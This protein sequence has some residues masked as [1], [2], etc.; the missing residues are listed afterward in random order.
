MKNTKDYKEIENLAYSVGAGIIVINHDEIANIFPFKDSVVLNRVKEVRDETNYTIRD[1]DDKKNKDASKD[2]A[3]ALL[4]AFVIDVD[5]FYTLM[6][7]D[8][9]ILGNLTMI[10]FALVIFLIGVILI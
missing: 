10:L 7:K 9:K 5:N 1:V 6:K 4:A 8:H 2:L 3:G